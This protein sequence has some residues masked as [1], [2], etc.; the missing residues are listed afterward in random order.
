MLT[1]KL[2]DSKR[3]QRLKT[4]GDATNFRSSHQSATR[5]QLALPLHLRRACVV[6]ILDIAAN[7]VV[8]FNG[9]KSTEEGLG[10]KVNFKNLALLTYLFM[11]LT[12]ILYC[13]QRFTQDI[14][15]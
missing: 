3:R 11:F 1:L 9:H 2:Y 4:P 8:V 12:D 5:P 7:D 14:A 6:S 10:Q 15:I 13:T